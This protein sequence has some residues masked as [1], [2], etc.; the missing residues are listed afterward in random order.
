MQFTFVDA[1]VFIYAFLKTKRQLQQSELKMKEAAKK[2]VTRISGGEKV[3]TSVVHFSEVCNILEDYLPFEEAVL[4]ERGL[5]FR[6]NL[7]IC[8]VTQEDYLKAASLAEDYHVGVNDAL[9]YLLMKRESIGAIYSFDTDF[10]V[11]TDIRRIT[12]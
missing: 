4:L 7:L 3:V 10:D 6:E 11:F 1:N 2:I 8:E 12:E 9:A 5:L